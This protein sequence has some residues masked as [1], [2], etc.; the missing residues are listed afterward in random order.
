MGF[1]KVYFRVINQVSEMF[2]INVLDF[3]TQ[4]SG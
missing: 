2:S 4:H 3:L 1:G